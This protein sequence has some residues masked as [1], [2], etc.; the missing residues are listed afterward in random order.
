MASKVSNN[1]T[2]EKFTSFGKFLINK[3]QRG[4]L[5]ILI[6]VF[7]VIGIWLHT[8]FP[9][10]FTFPDTGAYFLGASQNQFNIYRPMGYSHYLQFIHGINS[11]LHFIFFFTYTLYVISVLFFLYTLKYFWRITSR[12]LFYS[13][14]TCAIFAPRFLFASNFIMSDS[15]FSS[16]VLLFITSIIWLVYIPKKRWV[17]IMLALFAAFYQVRYSGI[18]YILIPIYALFIAFNRTSRSLRILLALLPLICFIGL[19]LHARK[20]YYQH[21]GINISSGFSG[22]QLINN[23][24]VLFPEAK[25]LPLNVFDDPQLKALHGFMQ[26]VPD[27]IFNADHTMNTSYM[28]N[29]E[30]PY[31]QFLFIYIQYTKTDYGT[32]WVACGDL[33]ARYAGALIKQYPGKY[34]KRFILPSFFSTFK[35]F[36][37]TEDKAP[38]V[39]DPVYS[40]YYQLE[41][42]KYEHTSQLFHMLNFP[43]QILNYFYWIS[44]LLAILYFISHIKK[45]RWKDKT[46]QTAFILLLLVLTHIGASALAAP[47]TTWRY[48]MP[49]FLPSL[50]FFLYN[51]NDFIQNYKIGSKLLFPRKK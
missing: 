2:I 36:D 12:P 35:S 42:D 24:S 41:I 50:A 30:L 8:L 17:L 1:N 51:L 32:A 13:L 18:F 11:S 44:L 10:P 26:S 25:H 45:E 46:W 31:K 29:K 48:T 28:W 23:A 37:I 15:L 22:W 7:I 49:V 5:G 9:Y 19:H 40:A 33:F 39:N 4:E 38:F 20:E 34:F 43:R 47:N 3:P 6:I 14:C 27:S 16:L 21:T